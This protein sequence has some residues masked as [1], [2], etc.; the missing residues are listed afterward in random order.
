MYYNVQSIAY[1]YECVWYSCV[2]YFL[3]SVLPI[4]AEQKITAQCWTLRR[5][6]IF[7]AGSDNH[8]QGQDLSPK[9]ELGPVRA[10]W[11]G[12]IPAEMEI[13]LLTGDTSPPST[14]RTEGGLQW[15]RDGPNWPAKEGSCWNCICLHTHICP[16]L[17]IRRYQLHP[18]RS[19]PKGDST[20]EVWPYRNERTWRLNSVVY[21]LHRIVEPLWAS[22]SIYKIKGTILTP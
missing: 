13:L 17:G 16:G 11:Q 7:L 8:G 4:T 15:K 10:G 18:I 14:R 3:S 2:F 21:D 22:A 9:W 19:Y 5:Q 1:V 12:A 20:K 6:Q